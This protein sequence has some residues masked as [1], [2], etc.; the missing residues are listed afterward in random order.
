MKVETMTKHANIIR[1]GLKLKPRN[2][3]ENNIGLLVLKSNNSQNSQKL[4]FCKA[5]TISTTI[6]SSP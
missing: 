3:Q 1:K 6:L 4:T 5:V 2:E